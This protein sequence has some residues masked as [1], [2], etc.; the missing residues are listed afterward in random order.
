MQKE[1]PVLPNQPT[2]RQAAWAF[3]LIELLVVIAI[4]AILAGMLLPALSRAKDK[5]QATGDINNVKQILLANHMYAGDNDERVSHPTWGG[6]LSGPDGWAYATANNGRIPGGP[7]APGSAAGRDVNSVQFSNQLAFFRISQLGPF[8]STHQVMW[9]P[10]D[11]SQ[12]GSGRFKTWWLARPVKITSY[13]WNGTIGSY[14]GPKSG[15]LANGKT[16]KLNDFLA[17]DIQLWEQNETDGFYFNDAGNNPLTGGEGVSQRHA[18]RGDYTGNADRGG[19]AMIG[20]FGGTAEFIKF[21]KFNDF[22]NPKLFKQP[23][24]LLNGPGFGGPAL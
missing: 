2:L 17:T 1:A 19:G 24:E 14:V 5:A 11:V 23:N 4:I 3:T 8:L 7:N 20:R 13:C 15:Q 12:R 6:D 21:K 16:Y 22:L 18:G 9:C 10:K